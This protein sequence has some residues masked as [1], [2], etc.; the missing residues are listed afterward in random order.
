M[1]YGTALEDKDRMRQ[2]F[3]CV[4]IAC[5]SVGL[6]ATP[7]TKSNMQALRFEISFP[8]QISDAPL[9]GRMMLGFS[10]DEKEEPRMGLDEE[11]AKSQQ[12]FAVDV[13]GL[14]AGQ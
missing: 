9:D 8:A 7:K 12:F 14:A 5:A 6:A 11:E 10:K 3:L 13:N 1:L 4:L 2:F